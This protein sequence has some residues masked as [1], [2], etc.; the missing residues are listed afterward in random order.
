MTYP[1]VLLGGFT[2]SPNAAIDT[3]AFGSTI[4]P[5]NERASRV[6]EPTSIALI[7]SVSYIQSVE[8]ETD[9]DVEFLYNMIFFNNCKFATI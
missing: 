7:R 8:T 2:F 1:D 9:F 3:I 6:P 5:P 4:A